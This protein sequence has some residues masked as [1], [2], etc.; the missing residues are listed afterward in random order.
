MTYEHDQQKGD[1]FICGIN[2]NLLTISQSPFASN[3]EKATKSQAKRRTAIK[4]NATTNFSAGYP[5]TRA[6]S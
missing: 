2:H 6:T 1:S 5:A 3:I 4:H